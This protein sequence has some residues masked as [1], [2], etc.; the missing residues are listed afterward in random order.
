MSFKKVLLLVGMVGLPSMSYALPEGYVEIK[1]INRGVWGGSSKLYQGKVSGKCYYRVLSGH[2]A[3]MTEVDCRDHGILVK[4]IP[5]KG[6]DSGGYF[7]T[8]DKFFRRNCSR[9][10]GTQKYT[11]TL[12]KEYF[13]KKEYLR[14]KKKFEE[15]TK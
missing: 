12:P 13:E 3:Y 11:C 14:L 1:D 7:D 2:Q 6:I 8:I 15:K 10:A 5:E 4:H 9:Q